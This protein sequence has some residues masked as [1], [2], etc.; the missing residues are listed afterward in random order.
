MYVDGEGPYSIV[1]PGKYSG[2]ELTE[3]LYLGGVPSFSDVSPDLL[4]DTG[5]VGKYS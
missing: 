5:F 3:P 1:D 2:L 4:V